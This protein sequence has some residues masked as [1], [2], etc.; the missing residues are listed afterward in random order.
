VL[1]SIVTTMAIT[2]RS[3]ESVNNYFDNKGEVYMQC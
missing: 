3:I 2:G 1:I